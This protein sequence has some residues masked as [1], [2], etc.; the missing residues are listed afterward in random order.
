[1]RRATKFSS[2]NGF[3]YLFLT[4]RARLVRLFIKC[5]LFV[6]HLW[7]NIEC[8]VVLEPHLDLLSPHPRMVQGVW[9]VCFR[10]PA[11]RIRVTRAE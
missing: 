9:L 1:M 11:T 6:C 10:T 7:I 4:N 2:L 5:D 3:V 8:P